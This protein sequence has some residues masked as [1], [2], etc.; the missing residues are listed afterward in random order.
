MHEFIEEGRRELATMTDPTAKIRRIAELH[1]S[2]LGDDRELAIVFQVELRGSIKFMQV[3]P[4]VS[5]YLD[6]IR[7]TIVARG[8]RQGLS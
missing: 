2:R 3:R 4:Q 5:E 8:R 1:L 7:G 6:I